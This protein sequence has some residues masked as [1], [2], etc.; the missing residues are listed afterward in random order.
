MQR[1]FGR[2]ESEGSLHNETEY[3]YPQYGESFAV[4]TSDKTFM[5]E[6]PI[7]SSECLS[8]R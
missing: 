5:S 6:M 1:T 2:I 4:L 7:E 3:D 8:Q